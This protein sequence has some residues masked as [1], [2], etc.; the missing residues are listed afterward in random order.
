MDIQFNTET[1]VKNTYLIRLTEEELTA[2]LIDPKPLQRELRKTRNAQIAPASNW[3]TAGH[4][5]PAR[6]K[7]QRQAAAK[8][9]RPAKVA[10]GLIDCPHGC[11]KQIVPRGLKMHERKCPRYQL[12]KVA[13][14]AQAATAAA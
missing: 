9:A 4:A 5:H 1:I 13:D 3:A 11:G 8:Q 10:P 14:R 7:G 2:A 6:N 12:R